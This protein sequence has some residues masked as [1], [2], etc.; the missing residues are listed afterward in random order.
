MKNTGIIR[1]LDNLGRVVLPI[2][3]RRALEIDKDDAVEIYVDS[4]Y[5]ILKKNIPTCVFCSNEKTLS[6]FKDKYICSNCLSDLH[7]V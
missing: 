2:D 5:I 7:R 3:V 6:K 1:K 4:E